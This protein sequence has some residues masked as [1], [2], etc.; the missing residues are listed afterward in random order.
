MPDDALIATAESIINVLKL[1]LENQAYRNATVPLESAKEVVLQQL[2][3][4]MLF[5]LS[6]GEWGSASDYPSE[7][8]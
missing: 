8:M 3:L 4:K 2:L 5:L 7:R 1:L 6:S